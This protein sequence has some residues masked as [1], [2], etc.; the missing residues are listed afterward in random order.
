MLNG[1]YAIKNVNLAVLGVKKIIVTSAMKL[2][3]IVGA[4]SKNKR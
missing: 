3:K 1:K 4:C 2:V